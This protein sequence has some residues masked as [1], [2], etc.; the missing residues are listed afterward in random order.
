MITKIVYKFVT[1]SALIGG[2]TTAA[3]AQENSALL[4]ILVKK[5]ILSSEEASALKE[6]LAEDAQKTITKTVSGGKKTTSI[7]IYG[8]LQGQYANLDTDAPGV[9]SVNHFFARRTR[10][11]VNY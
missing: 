10:L 3:F 8:R 7:S 6:E 2:L 5:G 4:N 9:A 1:L 11:G